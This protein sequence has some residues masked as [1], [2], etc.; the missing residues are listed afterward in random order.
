MTDT[1]EAQ[2][3]VQADAQ[4]AELA[5]QEL[6]VHRR[7]GGRVLDLRLF[8]REDGL[9]LRGRSPSYHVKQLAQ[10][11]LM[12]ATERRLVANEIEVV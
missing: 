9:V 4:S 2:P 3:E 10:H 6:H 11:A 1:T 5:S 12:H 7:I 8:V